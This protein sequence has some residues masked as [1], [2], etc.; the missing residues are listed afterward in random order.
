MQNKNKNNSFSSNSFAFEQNMTKTMRT[1]N[2]NNQ[3]Q[4]QLNNTAL[5]FFRPKETAIISTF[6]LNKRKSITRNS[7]FYFSLAERMHNKPIYYIPQ[8]IPTSITD[9]LK[10]F[11]SIFNEEEFLKYYHNTPSLKKTILEDIIKY[12]GNYKGKRGLFDTYAMF[13]YY[14]CHKLSYDYNNDQYTKISK[15]NIDFKNNKAKTDVIEKKQQDN[16]NDV[17]GIDEEMD[18]EEEKHKRSPKEILESGIGIQEEYCKLFEYFCKLSHLKVK[19]ITGNCKYYPRMKKTHNFPYNH[20]WN[21]IEIRNKWY[22]IDLTLG[23]GLYNPKKSNT[24]DQ[25]NPYY[26]LTLSD[27]LINSHFPKEINWQLLPK[28]ITYQQ[29]QR[30][31]NFYLGDFYCQVYH[32]QIQLLSHTHPYIK[33]NTLETNIELQVKESILRANLFLV[34]DNTKLSEIKYSYNEVNNIFT[35]SPFFPGNG[36]YI[37]KIIGRSISSTD[38][39]YLPYL[40]Y[41]VQINIGSEIKAISNLLRQKSKMSLSNLLHKRKDNFGKVVQPKMLSNDSFIGNK[42]KKKICMD[43]ST[44]LLFEPK[45]TVIKKGTEIKFKVKIKNA[46]AVALLDGR[47]WN[48]M[49]KREEDIWG[50]VFVIQTDN[51]SICSLKAC[52][53]YTEVFEFTIIKP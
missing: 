24:G 12:L 20:Y 35:F 51:V 22:F 44:A 5:S 21:I 38:L 19:R 43:N 34:Q 14:I 13:F 47:K 42:K 37:V 11:S 25:F 10:F 50:G 49:K 52:N 15:A 45:S 31:I 33:L 40:E 4:K 48:Y 29:Y 2:I 8:L 23:A 30:T 1:N 26:F 36:N 6:H 16:A 9:R 46:V 27:Y 7:S 32:H 28:T 53:V 41:K 39:I 3:N 17:E 18:I